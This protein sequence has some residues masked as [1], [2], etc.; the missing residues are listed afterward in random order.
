MMLRTTLPP[1][2]FP[3]KLLTQCYFA[4]VFLVRPGHSHTARIGTGMALIEKHWGA[5]IIA[6][7][8]RETYIHVHIAICTHSGSD[9]WKKGCSA[10]AWCQNGVPIE[11]T[12]MPVH[13]KVGAGVPGRTLNSLELT[14][15][16][17]AL[18]SW[19]HNQYNYFLYQ[20]TSLEFSYKIAMHYRH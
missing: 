7:D 5:E 12:S 20:L 15:L 4:C 18:T 14:C 6:E 16:F 9:R 8:G 11:P 19:I 17:R 1:Y 13:G 3:L 2:R 10:H